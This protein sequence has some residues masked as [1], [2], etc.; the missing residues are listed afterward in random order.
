[1]FP[2]FPWQ[3]YLPRFFGYNLSLGLTISGFDTPLR[4]IANV[5]KIFL[6]INM[7]LYF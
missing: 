2:F 4:C 5:G 7:I 1:M 6:M 3:H